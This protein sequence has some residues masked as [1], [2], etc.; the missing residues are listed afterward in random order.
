M[1]KGDIT[2]VSI[3]G[4]DPTNTANSWSPSGTARY[5]IKNVSG[6]RGSST[7]NYPRFKVGTYTAYFISDNNL[8]SGANM[9]IDSSVTLEIPNYS[10]AGNNDRTVNFAL[11]ELSSSS[12][13]SEKISV[14]TATSNLHWTPTS[15]K[16]FEVIG[17]IF[18]ASSLAGRRYDLHGETEDVTQNDSEG[19][20]DWEEGVFVEDI[21][22]AIL[23]DTM[24]LDSGNTGRAYFTVK[25][26]SGVG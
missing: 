20:L 15:G 3:T 5:L 7:S 26:L 18:T 23:D 9:M 6:Y 24:S 22:G 11:L 14:V 19:D 25:E 1:A 21:N 16:K 12:T 17:N 2:I 8:T 4:A 13:N 10:S